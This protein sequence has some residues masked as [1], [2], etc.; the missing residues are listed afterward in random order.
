MR[1]IGRNF[2]LRL[3]IVLVLVVGGYMVTVFIPRQR[4]YARQQLPKKALIQFR[5]TVNQNYIAYT[6]LASQSGADNTAS[7]LLSTAQQ[8]LTEANKALTAALSHAPKE[9]DKPVIAELKQLAAQ[10]SDILKEYIGRYNALLKPLSYLPES[11]LTLSKSTGVSRA[12]AAQ[13]AL[14][15]LAAAASLQLKNN[16]TSVNQ[17]LAPQG[18]G[19][20]TL[21][22]DTRQ[23]LADSAKCYGEFADQLQRGKAAAKGTLRSCNKAYATTRS[24]VAQAISAPLRTDEGN[25]LKDSFL[26]ILEKL[27]P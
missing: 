21:P 20:F 9:V 2:W 17:Q 4:E 24:K 26:A 23:A 27:T 3:G 18:S 5:N 22:E 11:D 16:D 15:Q 13:S 25:Q 7:L 12:R 14:S 10:Q 6:A 1:E 8:N 19:S